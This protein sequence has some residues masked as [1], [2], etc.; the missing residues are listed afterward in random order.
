MC[1]VSRWVV[2]AIVIMNSISSKKALVI[3]A[4]F[5]Y[6]FIYVTLLYY[7]ILFYFILFY[8]ILFL[9]EDMLT[10]FW[11]R[12]EKRWWGEWTE[13]SVWEKHRHMC[14]DR[15][16]NPQLRHMLPWPGIEPVTFQFLGRCSDQLSQTGQGCCSFLFTTSLRVKSKLLPLSRSSPSYRGPAQDTYIPRPGN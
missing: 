3:V 4:L 14:L 1:L 2:A 6:L 13:T 9:T 10:N 8:F 7:F 11:E 12:G 15:E 5:I 16:A